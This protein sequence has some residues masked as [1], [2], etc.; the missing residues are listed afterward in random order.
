MQS[1][2]GRGT[3]PNLPSIQASLDTQTK[4]EEPIDFVLTAIAHKSP[5]EAANAGRVSPDLA[6]LG[7]LLHLNDIMLGVKSF[8]PPGAR[9]TFLTEGQFFKS[10]DLFD[11]SNE[12]IQDYEEGVA[13]LASAVSPDGFRFVPLK[14]VV[15][16][17]ENFGRNVAYEKAKIDQ[18]E[19]GP[20]V[21]VMQRAMS[22]SQI[23][24]GVLPKDMAKTYAAIRNAKHQKLDGSGRSS[25]QAFLDEEYGPGRYIYCSLNASGK[26]DTLSIDPY[27]TPATNPPPQHGRGVL[28]GGTSRID[29]VPYQAVEDQ[30]RATHVHQVII[31]EL[32]QEPFGYI[33]QG[34]RRT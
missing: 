15:D 2:R 1:A 21:S 25:V 16:R 17:D 18:D 19:Y 8:Y 10:F 20:F 30:A 31:N 13:T 7:F 24:D 32:G 14:S 12:E 11:V 26:M 22:A 23:E 34:K 33:N 29:V 5:S 6:E 28:L 9:F 27:R 4:T 3:R